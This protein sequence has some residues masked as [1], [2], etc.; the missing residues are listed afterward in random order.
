MEQLR[1][2]RQGRAVFFSGE[3]CARYFTYRTLAAD[4]FVLF[5]D[6][7]T[8]RRKARLGAELGAAAAFFM[9]PEV[10]DLLDDLFSEKT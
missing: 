7:E 6:A 10:S 8:L 2:L 1:T 9:L 3:L 5:D 4:H